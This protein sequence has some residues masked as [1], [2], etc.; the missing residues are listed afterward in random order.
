MVVEDA[1]ELGEAGDGGGGAP[2]GRG[3]AG[4][5]AW[6]LYLREDEHDVGHNNT[7]DVTN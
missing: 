7:L 4:D 3:P 5:A 6:T 2:G 1:L